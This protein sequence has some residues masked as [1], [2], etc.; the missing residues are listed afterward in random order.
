MKVVMLISD[1]EHLTVHGP[2]ANE[3]GSWRACLTMPC[4]GYLHNGHNVHITL[5][6][7]VYDRE[8]RLRVGVKDEVM[9][10]D[11]K[12]WGIDK[13]VSAT[14]NWDDLCEIEM[15]VYITGGVV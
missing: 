4:D 11:R 3:D 15:V 13:F 5:L 10:K 2:F 6:T 9:T 1:T 7:D 14:H 8:L 12:V